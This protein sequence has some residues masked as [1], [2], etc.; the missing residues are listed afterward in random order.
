VRLFADNTI[1][2][3]KIVSDSDSN[4][5][6]LDLN[7]LEL[8]EKQWLMEFNSKKCQSMTIS[9]KRKPSKN[10]YFLHGVSLVQVSE[11]KYLGIT[12]SHD[13]KWNAHI[14]A[15]C[16]RAR[17]VLSFLGRN[18]KVANNK[19]KELAYF[20]LVR[21]HVEYCST[22]WDPYTKKMC[23]KVEMVQRKA[24]RFVLNKLGSAHYKDSVTEMLNNLK[25]STLSER[26]KQSRLLML[27]KIHNS[28]IPI[29]FGEIQQ[30][31]A[32]NGAQNEIK[33]INPRSD[34]NAHR[35]YFLP[36]TILD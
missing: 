31:Q 22:V 29:T 16:S 7:K 33:F 8:W 27:Y 5:L 36:R 6:Q 35:N 34:T 23:N 10:T 14:E 11:V 15:A 3:R 25:W 13:L 12:I 32:Y 18:L 20:A 9:R 19:T 24:A 28:L 4:S 30:K 26:R 1:L 2:Y 21:P 17:G